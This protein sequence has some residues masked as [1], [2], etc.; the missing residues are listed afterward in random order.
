MTVEQDQSAAGSAPQAAFAEAGSDVAALQAALSAAE[1]RAQESRDLYMRALAEVD[2]VR[3]RA[4]RDIEQA[5]KYALDRFANDLIAVKDSL[6]LGLE[7]SAGGAANAD[8][9]KSGTEATL[10][11]LGAAFDKAGIVEVVPQGERFN[12][13]LHEA[14]VTQPSAEHAPNTVLQVVQKGYQLNGRLLRPARVIVARE[15]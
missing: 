12:P 1:A 10:K 6:E 3:K 15:P 13:E 8:T 14:I 7:S 4:A 5:H 11:Q 9:L 2:N